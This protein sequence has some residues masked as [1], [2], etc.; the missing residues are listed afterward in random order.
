MQR[1]ILL[2]YDYQ[3]SNRTGRLH[4]IGLGRE[5]FKTGW[6]I[7]TCNSLDICWEDS[8][9][10]EVNFVK[11][12]I[13][14]YKPNPADIILFWMPSYVIGSLLVSFKISHN[15]QLLLGFRDL[16]FGNPQPID[17]IKGKLF[18]LFGNPV[19]NFA[20][21][22]NVRFIVISKEMSEA[23]LR[24]HLLLKSMNV[25]VSSTGDT[26]RTFIRGAECVYDIIYTGTF[27]LQMNLKQLLN[28]EEQFV[29]GFFGRCDH[30]GFEKY[31]VSEEKV[32]EE[33]GKSRSLAVFGVNDA[34]RLNRKIFM[35]L[36]T[37]LPIFYFGSEDN[38][39]VHI[40]RKYEG[41]FFNKRNGEIRH[42]IDSG[43]L[44]K[45]DVKQY[46]YPSIAKQLNESIFNS[47]KG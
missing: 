8:Y 29:L 16:W 25:I 26:E 13:E 17:S 18:R 2:A 9:R 46:M 40:L 27:D 44:Y 3:D 38:V 11:K 35:Y 30:R 19:V 24:K 12:F 15:F 39:T 41:V 23:L 45:R 22:I 10:G 42:I 47:N 4:N 7:V 34:S 1:K 28:L 43:E 21:L 37:S 5:L 20:G 36:Q 6:I 31:L 33:I 32:W 14:K